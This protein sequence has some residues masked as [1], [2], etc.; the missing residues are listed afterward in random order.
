MLPHRSITIG[1]GLVGVVVPNGPGGSIVWDHWV[2]TP[3]AHY[4]R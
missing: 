3:L 2:Y 4:Q 1:A